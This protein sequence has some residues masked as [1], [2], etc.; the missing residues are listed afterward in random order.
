MAVAKSSISI[1]APEDYAHYLTYRVSQLDST[2]KAHAT[3][4]LREHSLSIVQW[5][6]IA[7]IAGSKGP[8]TSTK[9]VNLIEMDPGQFSRTLKA[10]IED[11][12][13]IRLKD[14][15]DNRQHTLRLSS[16]GRAKFNKVEPIMKKRRESLMSGIST[17]DKDAFFRAL[18][19]LEA[20][21]KSKLPDKSYV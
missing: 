13:I 1:S 11:G 2:M 21:V 7:L 19:Q 17:N 10:L 9:L 3:H 5:R 6:L 16:A 8:V 15:A 18:D 12:L 14:K 4:M 20:N